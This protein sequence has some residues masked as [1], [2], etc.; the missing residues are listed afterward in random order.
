MYVYIRTLGAVAY[1]EQ[2]MRSIKFII[3]VYLEY[4]K[5]KLFAFLILL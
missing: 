4:F 3:Y 1:F 2:Y 5:K